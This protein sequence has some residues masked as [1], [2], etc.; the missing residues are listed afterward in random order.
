[1]LGV[2]ARR[3]PGDERGAF[4]GLVAL[5]CLQPLCGRRGRG[6]RPVL[7]P[8]EQT[9]AP[10]GLGEL[11]DWSLLTALD[12]KLPFMLSGGLTTDNVAD[13]VRTVKPFGVDVSSGVETAPGEKDAGLIRAFISAARSAV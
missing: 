6:L 5:V 10:G 4:E 12:P 2:L 9:A 13:A 8:T 7:A 1:M 11:F 3:V